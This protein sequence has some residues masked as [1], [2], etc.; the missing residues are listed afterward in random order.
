M[1]FYFVAGTDAR[2]RANKHLLCTNIYHV[3]GTAMS[4]DSQP[5]PIGSSLLAP[6][7]FF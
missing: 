7:I 5:P 6:L 3:L 4:F 2:L 1:T